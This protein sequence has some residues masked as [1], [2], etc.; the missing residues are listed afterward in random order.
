MRY[1]PNPSTPVKSSLLAL[2]FLIL[3][4]HGLHGGEEQHVTDGGAVGH[5]HDHAVKAETQAA[6]GGHRRACGPSQA[7]SLMDDLSA[8]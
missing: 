2:C 6:R 7:T 5:Q 4:T 8:F 3:L 1:S